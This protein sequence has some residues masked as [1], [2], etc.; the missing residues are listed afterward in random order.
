VTTLLIPWGERAGQLVHVDAVASGSGCGC[1][2]PSC[3]DPLVA[4]KGESRIHHFAHY[5]GATCNPETLLH[6]VGKRLLFER[7]VASLGSGVAIPIRWTCEHCHEEHEGN[8]IKKATGVVLE[9]SLGPCRPDVTLIDG[10]GSPVA[11]LEIVVSHRPDPTV[12][13]YAAERRIPLAEFHM[14]GTGDLDHITESEVLIPT[15]MDLCMRPRCPKCGKYL[16]K[17]SLHVIGARCWK[18]DRAMKAAL[19]T[20][21]GGVRGPEALTEQERAVARENGVVLRLER[22][23]T[24]RGQWKRMTNACGHCGAFTST[25]YLHNFWHEIGPSTERMVRWL[26]SDCGGGMR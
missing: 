15:K 12:L 17:A 9:K 21:L 10:N 5:R 24:R 6:Q 25:H 8:L 23:N 16:Q 4:K 22:G 7:I 1:V 26:C 19:L 18:C 13:A 14:A 2:C 20:G 11:L 3:G